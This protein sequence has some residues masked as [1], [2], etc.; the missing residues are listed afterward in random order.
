MADEYDRVRAAI[1]EYLAASREPSPAHEL[2]A[3]LVEAGHDSAVVSFVISDL[4]NHHEVRLD[5]RQQL[6]ARLPAAS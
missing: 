5:E 2:I 6:T 1:M 3:R 4:L